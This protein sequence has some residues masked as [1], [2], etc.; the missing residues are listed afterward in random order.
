MRDRPA[1]PILGVVPE[2]G[3][4]PAERPPARQRKEPT[5]IVVRNVFQAKVGQGGELARIM[6]ENIGRTAERGGGPG[7]WRVLTDISGPFDTVVLEVEAESLAEWERVM[8]ELFADPGWR[9]GFARVADLMV[10][11][12][13]GLYTLEARG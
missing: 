8:P 1:R 4:G 11:G 10:S 7:A 5:M 3:P 9:E 13:R 2:A 6:A 12:Q